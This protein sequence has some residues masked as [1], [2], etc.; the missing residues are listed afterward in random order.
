[1]TRKMLSRRRA[2]QPSR[3]PSSISFT[4]E[5]KLMF[6]DAKLTKG[7]LLSYYE[8]IAPRL[9][10]FLKDR[11][12]TVG[13]HHCVHAAP[14]DHRK[15]GPFLDTNRS[16]FGLALLCCRPAAWAPPQRRLRSTRQPGARSCLSLPAV[17][18]RMRDGC[19]RAQ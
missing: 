8:Q 10:P 11:P 4:H 18:R 6:P 2:S 17:T 1:M 19:V 7:D 12:I 13:K 5:S 15:Q 14:R 3:A 16:A 9:L